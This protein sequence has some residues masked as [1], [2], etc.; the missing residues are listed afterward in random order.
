MAFS[1]SEGSVDLPAAARSVLPV[2]RANPHYPA[3]LCDLPVAPEKLWVRGRLPDR[4]ARLVAIVGSRAATGAGCQRARGL[5]GELGQRGFAV[6][7]GGAFGIDAAAHEGALAAGAATY[8]VLGCGIDVVYPDRHAQLFDRIA[9]NGGLL[10]EYAPGTKPRR[11]QFP[12]RNRIIA[13]LG[14]AVIVVEAR[15]RS[16]ALITATRARELGRLLL[17]V[18]G[19]SGTDALVHGGQALP[20]SSADDVA[21]A[22]AGKLARPVPSPPELGPHGE[23]IAA[24]DGGADTPVLL[25]QRLG[26][27]LADILAALALAE[28]DGW[29]ER[30]GGDTYEVVD[31]A[32]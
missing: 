3:S 11:G 2:D 20:V 15:L 19:S 12:V 26:R 1:S 24:I 28:L 10:S 17:A 5:A 16:G 21:L 29:V 32:C 27:P 22:L 30:A 18:P 6:V 23:L 7:S 14:Q 13:A 31:R 25:C 4:E 8:A 9:A